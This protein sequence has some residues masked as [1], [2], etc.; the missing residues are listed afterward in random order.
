MVEQQPGD[1]DCSVPE[2]SKGKEGKSPAMVKELK[3]MVKDKFEVEPE[4]QGLFT[5]GMKTEGEHTIDE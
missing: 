5:Q 4:R 1:T 3:M 2:S